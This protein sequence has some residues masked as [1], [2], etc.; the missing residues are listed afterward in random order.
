MIVGKLLC[1]QR[2]NWNA[3]GNCW[4][5]SNNRT[6]RAVVFLTF[7]AMF[8][9]SKYCLYASQIFQ[10]KWCTFGIHSSSQKMMM[11]MMMKVLSGVSWPHA[12]AV[13]FQLTFRDLWKWCEEMTGCCHVEALRQASSAHDSNNVTAAYL[14][15]ILLDFRN[16]S[17]SPYHDEVIRMF[18]ITQCREVQFITFGR[19]ASKSSAV[20][21]SA[22][23]TLRF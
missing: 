16:L 12:H 5:I 4:L 21:L 8:P 13:N 6:A 19:E 20:V 23:G 10:T 2:N 1:D 9:L 3:S 11:M 7:C 15:W 17:D 14:A 18:W 22:L